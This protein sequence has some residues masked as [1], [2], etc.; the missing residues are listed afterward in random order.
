M[1]AGCDHRHKGRGLCNMHLHR[2]YRHGDPAIRL[3]SAQPRGS[4]DYRLHLARFWSRVDKSGV[5]GCWIW[6]GGDYF[7]FGRRTNRVSPAR[8]A[9]IATVGGVDA[10]VTR[11]HRTCATL[12]CINPAHR[13]PIIPR[14]KTQ[15]RFRV[16]CPNGHALTPRNSMIEIRMMKGGPRGYV[17]CRAC[18]NKQ[19]AAR[20]ARRRTA[21]PM[22]LV[23]Q[24]LA[25]IG[26]R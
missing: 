1:I 6:R 17:R 11:F 16:S 21:E 24:L 2:L 23:A 13:L 25:E 9:W 12:S 15:R 22:G 3:V 4:I 26:A 18:H 20:K 19:E 7:A 14:T 8:F 5:S 10:R